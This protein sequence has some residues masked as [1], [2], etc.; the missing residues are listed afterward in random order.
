MPSTHTDASGIEIAITKDGDLKLTANADG[1]SWLEDNCADRAD[2]DVLHDILDTH[3]CNGSFTPFEAGRANPFVG[4][5]DA[6]CIAEAMTLD[7]DED[8]RRQI[9]GRFWYLK[10]YA[11]MDM[12]GTLIN[13]GELLFHLGG[14]AT[15]EAEVGRPKPARGPRP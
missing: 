1:V 13:K 6:P 10:N 15:L 12:V 7:V 8:G 14:K 4:L 3:S 5:T 9:V 11:T 2:V